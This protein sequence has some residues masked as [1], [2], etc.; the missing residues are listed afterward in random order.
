MTKLSTTIVETVNK[1]IKYNK[2]GYKGKEIKKTY[3][4]AYKD[5]FRSLQVIETLINRFYEA[6]IANKNYVNNPKSCSG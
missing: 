5:F 4:I 3:K 6:L 1:Y 2:S